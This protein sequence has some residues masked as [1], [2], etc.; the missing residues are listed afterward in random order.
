M[1]ATAARID[2]GALARNYALLR[3]R[4]E[5]RPLI[6]VVKADAY[7]HGAPAVVRRL[8]R[9]GCTRFAVAAIEEAAAL[10]GA[11]IDAALLLLSGVRGEEEARQA[12]A[13]SL[14]PV[15]Q[16]G[17][18]VAWLESA[19]RSLGV[20][21]AVHAE[22]DTGMRRFGVP[23]DEA[24]ALLVRLAASEALRLEGVSTHFA[25]ADE[26]DPAASLAQLEVF[27]RAL[28]AARG[29][30]V[31][32]G[33][34]HV[35][36][37]A[38]LLVPAVWKEA[39]AVSGAARPGIALYGVAPAPRLGETGLRPVM[40]LRTEIAALRRVAAGEGVGYGHVFRAPHSGWVATLPIGYAD[41]VPWTAA[42]R[43]AAWVA[44]RRRPLAGRVSMD[45]TTVW[46]DEDRARI[47][48]EAILFGTACDGGRLDVEVLAEAAGTIAYELLVRVGARVPRVFFP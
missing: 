35:A 24:P 42:G 38:A 4:A 48:E 19:A 6:A 27:R 11:G 7:G 18:Q 21:A 20:R 16:A 3:E 5:G 43:G 25:R 44:G 45:S 31:D 22:I 30:G 28:D 17:E 37:S 10:R 14:V 39:A 8:R 47:G 33:L 2:L 46:L 9:E 1:P 12:L 15:V 41:G 29:R 34:V 23:A 36:N 32:P 13:L 40:T 26:A